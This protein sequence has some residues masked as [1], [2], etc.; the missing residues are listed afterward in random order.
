MLTWTKIECISFFVG[1]LGG[2]MLTSKT[3]IWYIKGSVSTQVCG[4]LNDA[5]QSEGYF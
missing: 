2:K 3:R 5:P 1:S 4:V